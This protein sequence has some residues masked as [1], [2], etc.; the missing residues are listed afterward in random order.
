[1]KLA[2]A[3]LKSKQGQVDFTLGRRSHCSALRPADKLALERAGGGWSWYLRSRA[4]G[5]GTELLPLAERKQLWGM[6]RGMSLVRS[7]WPKKALP[8]AQQ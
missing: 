2:K 1:M 6:A 4:D 3:R 5:R 7:F 8:S